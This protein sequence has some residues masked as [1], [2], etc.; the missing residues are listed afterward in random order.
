M[1]SPLEPRVS[2]GRPLRKCSCDRS[3]VD[4]VLPFERHLAD[5]VLLRMMLATQAQCPIIGWLE[6]LPSVGATAN[7]R[8]FARIA[9][10]SWY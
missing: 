8:A 7:M 6:T 2:M 9:I 10:A 3:H 1:V 4:A 5:P